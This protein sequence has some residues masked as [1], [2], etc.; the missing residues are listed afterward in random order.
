MRET[1]PT[2]DQRWTT[3]GGNRH[4]CA[5]IA[6]LT[7]RVSM[8]PIQT[9]PLADAGQ[10]DLGVSLPGTLV[11]C[12][13][14]HESGERMTVASIHGAWT[15][16]V[17]WKNGG[18]ISADASV[19]RLVSDLSALVASQRGHTIIV[20]GDLNILHGQG[21]HGSAYWQARYQ[22]V[23]ARITVAWTLNWIPADLIT[24]ALNGCLTAPCGYARDR[25]RDGVDR[26]PLLAS[27]ADLDHVVLVLDER[28]HG[29]PPKLPHLGQFRRCDSDAQGG[30]ERT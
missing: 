2:V 18:W 14:T 4:C 26:L 8:R 24:G 11:A 30:S 9:R 7:D 15:P 22:T 27:E 28:A 13:L 25:F 6:R 20:A 21:E 17:P 3:A 5:A 1:V 19:H 10:N 12:E 29:F 23:F 16:P